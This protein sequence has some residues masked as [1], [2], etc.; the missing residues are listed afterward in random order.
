MCPNY[1]YLLFLVGTEW[2]Y[3][4]VQLYEVGFNDCSVNFIRDLI[5]DVLL[6]GFTS[7]IE[8]AELCF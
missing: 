4:E 6:Y 7:Y 2:E 3:E 1:L 5:C 8:R